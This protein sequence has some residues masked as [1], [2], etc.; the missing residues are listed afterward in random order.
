MNTSP[1]CIWIPHFLQCWKASPPH[2]PV[3]H[4]ATYI[5]MKP[6]FGCRDQIRNP[7]PFFCSPEM[8]IQATVKRGHGCSFR[9][10]VTRHHSLLQ[11]HPL[12]R[13]SHLCSLGLG[14]ALHLYF[15]CTDL[16]KHPLHKPPLATIRNTSFTTMDF[17]C[18]F[19][20]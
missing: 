18:S 12:H 19:P 4:T 8:C 15:C 9:G 7:N 13:N 1:D 5:I 14:R 2:T 11:P 3:H 6:C 17:R 16:T 20:P 10:G